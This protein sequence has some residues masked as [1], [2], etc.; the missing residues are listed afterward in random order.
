M[1]WLLL[2]TDDNLPVEVRRLWLGD[3]DDNERKEKKQSTEKE[4]K[5]VDSAVG[6][7]QPWWLAGGGSHG[8]G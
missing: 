7:Y 3:D 5:G 1:E 4:G 2:Y 8:H 6:F